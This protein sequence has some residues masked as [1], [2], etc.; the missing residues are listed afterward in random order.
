MAS[1]STR[2]SFQWDDPLR[3]EGQLTGDERAVRD[4]AH[5][6]AQGELAAEGSGGVPAREDR[7]RD[8][9][10]DGRARPARRDDPRDLRRRRPRLCRYGLIAREVERVDSGY[11]SMMSVQ[12]SL[13]MLPI[14]AFGTRRTKQKYLPKLATGEWIGCFGLTEPDH[15]SDPGAWSRA[16]ARSP[17]GYRLIG[18]KTWITNAPIA[19]VFVVWAKDDD[20][21]DPRLRAGEGLEGPRARRRSTARSA[22]APRSPARSCWTTCSCPEENLLPEVR[23]LKGPFTCL[24]CGAL[25]HRLGRARRGGGLLRD[26]RGNTC[27]TASSSAARSPP[28][29]SSRRSSPTC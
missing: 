5:D 20:G 28:T 2:A 16:R 21:D 19:D 25:R 12:S 24:N 13:V 17:G 8:L 10:R 29:S 22:C 15:G 7:R 6:F 11:R 14:D 27:S 4:A 9:P 23:G 18:A 26:A 1:A 3:L